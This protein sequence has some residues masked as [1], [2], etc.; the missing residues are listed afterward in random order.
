[1]DST[2]EL[3]DFVVT[4]RLEDMPVAVRAEAIRT[5]LNWMGCAIGGSRHEAVERALTALQA[6]A[7]PR[8]ASL[9]G[10]HERVDAVTAALINGM[11]GHAFD[12][13]DTHLATIIHPSVSVLPAL[14]AFAE[15]QTRTAPISGATLLHALILGVEVECRIG[16]AVCP[17]HFDIGWH[18]TSTCGVFGAAAAI[19][20]LLDLDRTRMACALGL[21]ASQAAGLRENLASMGKFLHAGRAAQNGLQAAL[22]AA[23]DFTA[24]ER[25]IEALRGFAYVASPARRL[26]AISDRLGETFEIMRNSYKPYPC[27]IVLHPI[28]DGCLSLRAANALRAQDVVAV[29]TD[30]NSLVLEV[31]GKRAP[32]NG[33]EAKFS[34]YHC[35]AVAIVDGAVGE[36]QFTDRRAADPAI[37][38]LA[39]RVNAV[40]D[41]AM[42]SDAARV[43]IRLKD[44]RELVEYVEHACGSAQ[45]PLTEAQ[46][47]AKFTAL[48]EPILGR[49]KTARLLALCRDA[50][51]IADAGE[52]PRAARR[53]RARG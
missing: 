8:Q 53:P 48:S 50:E 47:D 1:M 44:G 34:V 51:A 26:A 4:S 23:H 15:A 22:L 52:M 6:F 11:A 42:S 43:R 14:C 45:R 35:V 17:D 12:F 7:G 27:G 33:V 46:L 5:L 10:R 36:D 39:K 18:A 2:R 37:D 41:P 29:D 38:A 30:V 32:I 20:K 9:I 13:D 31:T 24:S 16:L 3:A 28:I 49:R 40:I 25:A 19:G 21:A